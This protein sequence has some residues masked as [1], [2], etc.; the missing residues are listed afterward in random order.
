MTTLR[1]AVCVLL[2]LAAAR[3]EGSAKIL[4]QI[5]HEKGSRSSGEQSLAAALDVDLSEHAKAGECKWW[6]A[7]HTNT[8]GVQNGWDTKCGW[9][10]CA[11]CDECP[12]VAPTWTRV[13][14]PPI[15]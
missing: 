2:V 3:A 4:N 12:T 13:P 5:V 14:L 15:G 7:D 8:E 10:S 9:V 1:A 6:C 11:G